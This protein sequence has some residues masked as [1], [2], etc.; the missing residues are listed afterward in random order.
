MDQFF[1]NLANILPKL[2]NQFGL[3]GLI[4]AV[5]GF[6][7]SRQLAPES[8][9][10]QLAAGSVGITLIIFGQVFYYLRQIPDAQRGT[11]IIVLFLTFCIFMIIQLVIATI[12]MTKS[13]NRIPDNSIS[14]KIPEGW[15]F[16]NTAEEIAKLE[17]MTLDTSSCQQPFLD[18]IVK[19]GP[20]QAATSEALLKTLAFRVTG[21][22]VHYNVVKLKDKGIYEIHCN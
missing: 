3:I 22:Q 15:V 8:L 13:R 11:L 1:K 2:R 7:V 17:N 16:R 5:G 20:I 6:V 19:P 12:F 18:T 9:V 10:T 14:F 4:V 21:K